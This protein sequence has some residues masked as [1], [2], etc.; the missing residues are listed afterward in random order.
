[1]TK[2]R[3][4]SD[5]IRER[6]LAVRT[7]RNEGWSLAKCATFYGVV[8]G[9]LT[10]SEDRL[11]AEERLEA[12][13]HSKTIEEILLREPERV[14]SW[15]LKRCKDL[16]RRDGKWDRRCRGLKIG[17]RCVAKMK[18]AAQKRKALT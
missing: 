16:V 8:P 2:L 7:R 17:C 5:K 13:E 9:T 12:A 11:R 14:D 3:V 1:M 15:T 6:T 4:M 10:Q 18:T